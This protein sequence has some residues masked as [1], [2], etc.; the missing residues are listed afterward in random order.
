MRSPFNQMIAEKLK[1]RIYRHKFFSGRLIDEIAMSIRDL[2][3]QRK[4]TQEELAKT[5]GMN[6][7]AISRMEQASYGKWGIP[8]LLRVA[9]GLDARLEVRLRPMEEVI[10]E[11]QGMNKEKGNNQEFPFLSLSFPPGQIPEPNYANTQP[12]SNL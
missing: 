9:E 2:R 3:E 8:T 7:S 4:M 6:Q 12:T 1:N 10:T 5:T 11:Y